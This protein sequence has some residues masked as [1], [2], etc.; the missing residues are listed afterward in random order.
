MERI[1]QTRAD[2]LKRK[3]KPTKKERG[4]KAIKLEMKKEKK[5]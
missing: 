4:L 5:K 2:S 1:N 3:K